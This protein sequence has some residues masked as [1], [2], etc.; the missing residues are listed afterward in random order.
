MNSD[1]SREM[2]IK[3]TNLRNNE[4]TL[5]NLINIFQLLVIVNILYDFSLLMNVFK[6]K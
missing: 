3:K 2:Y 5:K 4:N 6:P 1:D